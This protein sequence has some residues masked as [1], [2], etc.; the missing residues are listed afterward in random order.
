[1][2]KG[3]QYKGEYNSGKGFFMKKF[4]LLATVLTGFS[5][6][7][8]AEEPT[9]IK[10][11]TVQYTAPTCTNCRTTTQV[12]TVYPNAMPQPTCSTCETQSTCSTCGVQPVLVKDSQKEIA[13]PCSD[14]HELGMRNPIF[15]LRQGQVL[16]RETGGVF[17]EPKHY[18]K[19]DKEDKAENRGGSLYTTL[20]YGLTDR[21]SITAWG[22]KN[23]SA[24]KKKSLGPGYR[25][26]IP[27]W[28]TYKARLDTEVHV[29]DLCNFD[30][31]LGV[32]G[33]WHREKEQRGKT[34]HRVS[35]VEWGPTAKVG[36][37]LGWFTL[38]T[39]GSYTWDHVHTKTYRSDMKTR[40]SWKRTHG[41]YVNPGIYFQPSKW[42]GLDF[43]YQK[44]EESSVRPQWNIRADFYP[45]KNVSLSL[46]GNARQPYKHPMQM[47]GVTADVG[48]IF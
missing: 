18:D 48:I 16:A 32:E 34:A 28:H 31:F 38:Y 36:L 4:L 27:H 2:K 25:G 37:T 42:F 7:A 5:L 20:S 12:R 33:E 41:Y 8:K 45:Y 39:Q 17:K 24:P 19:Y 14:N 40:K 1:M 43:D 21:W 10:T 11:T 47:Y 46:Q 44:H 6:V 13:V 9:T 30:A 3:V 22:G 15:T 26:A 23:Y 29:L 35:G